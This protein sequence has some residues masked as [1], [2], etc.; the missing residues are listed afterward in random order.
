[1]RRA[2]ALLVV[3]T[4]PVL[5]EAGIRPLAA[6]ARPAAIAGVASGATRFTAGFELNT[7][8]RIQNAAG[9]GVTTAIEYNGPPRPG[10]RLGK[11]LAADHMTVIDAR[12]SDVLGEWECHRTHTVAPP[13]P[14]EEDWFCD[15][16]ADP[17]VDSPAVVLQAVREWLREDAS[18]PLVSGYWVLDD[19]A[20]WDGG[21][22]RSLLAEVHDAI[23]EITPG[24]PAI[25]GFGGSIEPI[26]QHGGFEAS[27]A[28][29]YSNAGCDM[30]GLYNYANGGSQ[31]SSGEGLEWTMSILLAEEREDLAE[32]GWVQANT[33]MLG[34]D[35]GWSGHFAHREYEPGLSAEQM[36]TQARAFCAAGAS[37]IAW[38]GW[39][40]VRREAQTAT[41]SPA[42]QAGIGQGIAACA[43][44]GAG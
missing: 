31:L 29:N 27:T 8:A 18:N 19:W 12:I 3:A 17:G 22:A 10:S 35:Q 13:P 11:T 4:V 5:L 32:E 44:L 43:E 23:E 28:A 20:P 9:L 7:R 36:A 21:S 26:G 6:G 25:C 39:G 42:I 16:D 1:M 30:V 2:L 41:N 38:Y 37:S 15:T 24:R 40:G 33:P 34:I 14:G